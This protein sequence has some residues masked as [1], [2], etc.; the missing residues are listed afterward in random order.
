MTSPAQ[1]SAPPWLRRRGGPVR[2]TLRWARWSSY[3]VAGLLGLALAYLNQV[4]VPDFLKV[5]VLRQLA[6]RGLDLRFERMRLRLGRGVVADRVEFQRSRGAPG[7]RFTAR[8]VQLPIRWSPLLRG[9]PPEIAGVRLRDARLVFPLAATGDP[10]GTTPPAWMLEG[11][12][13]ELIFQDDQNWRLVFLEGASP[14]GRFRAAGTVTN[15][16]A[17]RGRQPRTDSGSQAW[18]REIARVH[19]WLGET[20]F[21]S[22]PVLELSFQADALRPERSTAGLHLRSAG[23]VTRQ[24]DFQDLWVSLSLGPA[25]GRPGVL[26]AAAR[27]ASGPARTPWGELG[28]LQLDLDGLGQTTNAQPVEFTADLRATD[29]RG[30]GGR[31]RQLEIHLSSQATARPDAPALP[32][33][34][35]G[36]ATP[37]APENPGGPELW[38]RWVATADEC[39]FEHQG[40]RLQAGQLHFQGETRHDFARWSS[41]T[42]TARLRRAVLPGGTCEQAEIGLHARPRPSPGPAPDLAGQGFWTGLGPLDLQLQLQLGSL[43]ARPPT[44]AASPSNAPP[45]P[46][47][48][49]RVE[50]EIAWSAPRVQVRRL[51]ARMGPGTLEAR[52]D[53]DVLTRRAAAEA[54]STLDPTPVVPLLTPATQRWLSQYGWSPGQPPRLTAAAHLTLPAWTNRAPDWRGTVLPTL[55][56]AGQILATNFS[57]RG[58]GGS[59]AE[60]D[61]TFTNQ[62]W[63]LPRIAASLPEGEVV[64]QHRSDEVT[65]DY[66]FGLDATVQP[67]AALPVVTDPKARQILEETRF[68]TTPRVRGEVWGRWRARERTGFRADVAL[69][70]VVFRGEPLEA[71]TARVHY[72]NLVLRVDDARIRSDGE[73]RVEQAVYDIPGQRLGFTNARSTLPV[74]RVGRIIGP[75]TARTL[76]TL[77]FPQNPDATLN[78]VFGVRSFAGTDATIEARVPAFHWWRLLTTNVTARL[79]FRDETLAITGLDAELCRGRVAGSLF[80][81][82]TEPAD[83][84]FR[85]DTT[86][87][88]VDAAAVVRELFRQTNQLEGRLT[89]RMAMVEARS[90]DT[91]TWR[92]HGTVEMRDGF[93]WGL[94]VFGLFSPLFNA[95]AP[96]L[97]EARFSAGTASFDF[98]TNQIRTPDMRFQAGPL[99]LDYRGSVGFD[100]SL[101]AVM[102]AEIFRQTPVLGSLLNMV[103]SP[104]SKLLEYRIRGTMGKPVIDPRYVPR[105]LLPVLRPVRSLRTLLP[106]EKE[107]S[108]PAPPAPAP[109]P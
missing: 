109:P 54:V 15:A 34:I 71:L 68:G 55:E 24:G 70:N 5:R 31:A 59:R 6:D 73:A 3:L 67:R 27:L 44:P 51:L 74:Q 43:S 93:L 25:P 50:A 88:N 19:D 29:V 41:L 33:R 22:R 75:K 48:I 104:V 28:S 103:L 87:T 98:S 86:F 72:S 100:G 63:F 52:A 92:G 49:P 95:L 16:A 107:P 53:L 66:W 81:D 1:P 89:G 21:K 18:Q 96:G 61:L 23:A 2:R 17:L 36:G 38:S 30:P 101:D 4:G 82:F 11:V 8:E 32:W 12:G 80:L 20:T 58:I 102:N 106:E 26:A 77:G 105:F 35:P 64:L 83:T 47:L 69:T 76:G 91:N 10:A 7:E 94:P 45:A 99:Q 65:R 108:T 85:F 62:V 79:H 39:E 60:V 37:P 90:A 42:G 46:I 57:F 14:A 84:A 56:L 9:R 40:R 97:G 78:G 13:A